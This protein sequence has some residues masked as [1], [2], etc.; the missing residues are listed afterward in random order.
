M[1]SPTLISSFFDA[2]DTSA[3]QAGSV[4]LRM[5]GRVE[6][7]SK[8][9]GGTPESDALSAVDLAAQDV[10]LEGLHRFLPDVSVDAEEDTATVGLFPPVVD[11]VGPVVVLDPVDG[12]L[13]YLSGSDDWAVMAGLLDGG[14]F[15]AAHLFFPAFD[16]SFRASEP[17]GTLVREGRGPWRTAG[18]TATSDQVLV[19]P[20]FPDA[21]AAALGGLGFR[22][23]LCRC[24]AVEGAVGLLGRGAGAVSHQSLGR[25][26]AIPLYASLRAGATVL[27]GSAVWNG[28]DPAAMGAPAPTVVAASA[29]VAERVRDAVATRI[30]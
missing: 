7:L 14:R 24:S 18:F 3:R 2:L 1:S 19:P 5:Q 20:R 17:E 23:T 27:L 29:V 8:A 30:G 28:E 13:S 15:V 21:A 22:P 4:A 9:G 10:V 12:S 6:N 16:I 25:R 11:T 26:H